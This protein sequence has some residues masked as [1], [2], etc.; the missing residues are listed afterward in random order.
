MSKSAFRIIMLMVHIMANF[1]LITVMMQYDVTGSWLSFTLFVLF[2]T[3][4]AF[5]LIFHLFTFFRFLK[6]NS[7]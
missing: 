4:L 2:C 6:T 3:G 5:L 7:R 1:M